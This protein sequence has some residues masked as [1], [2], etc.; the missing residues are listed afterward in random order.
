[1]KNNSEIR[2]SL[3]GYFDSVTNLIMFSPEGNLYR[4]EIEDKLLLFGIC[5][6][7]RQV[8]D[9]LKAMTQEEILDRA[10]KKRSKRLGYIVKEEIISNMNESYYTDVDKKGKPIYI[11]LTQ[12]QLKKKFV[13]MIRTYHKG[14]KKNKVVDKWVM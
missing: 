2:K 4:K 1:M 8:T 7:P 9:I 5:N 14:M 13:E 10:K 12:K 6:S 11:K 3:Y